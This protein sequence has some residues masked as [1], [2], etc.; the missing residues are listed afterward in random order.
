MSGVSQQRTRLKAEASWRMDRFLLNLLTVAKSC[1]FIS[2]SIPDKS[3]V[4]IVGVF[5]R[6]SLSWGVTGNSDCT[7]NLRYTELSAVKEP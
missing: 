1:Q 6:E 5:L 3:S 7:H 2:I 4:V